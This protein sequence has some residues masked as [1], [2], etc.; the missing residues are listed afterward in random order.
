MAICENYLRTLRS[1]EAY[2][3]SRFL[4][5]K[6][7][8]RGSRSRGGVV[9]IPSAIHNGLA[10]I[11]A[12]R[13]ARPQGL[14]DAQYTLN[15]LAAKQIA[16][17]ELTYRFQSLLSSLLKADKAAR[18]LLPSGARGKHACIQHI[19]IPVPVVRPDFLEGTTLHILKIPEA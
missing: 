9:K 17:E 18:D 6:V 19:P 5:L 4:G 8:Q 11:A 14:Q 13:G 3:R 12:D 16:L 7:T 1:A 2:T 15:Y 10:D